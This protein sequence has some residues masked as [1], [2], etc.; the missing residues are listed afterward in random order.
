MDIS[1]YD[2]IMAA[3]IVF[4]AVVGYMCGITKMLRPVISLFISRYL[5]K[6]VLAR[7]TGM[8]EIRDLTKKMLETGIGKLVANGSVP[9]DVAA[10]LAG[11]KPMMTAGEMFASYIASFAAF[12]VTYVVVRLLVGLVIKTITSPKNY[13]LYMLDKTAGFTVG[14]LLAIALLLVAF[15]IIM[16]MAYVGSPWAG[17][18]LAGIHKSV[19]FQYAM[20]FI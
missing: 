9:A 13:M 15:M 2:L 11:S 6:F 14:A 12:A 8:N 7:F 17:S 1:H 10:K 19:V 16:S 18:M 5:F 3:V 4:G 20:K